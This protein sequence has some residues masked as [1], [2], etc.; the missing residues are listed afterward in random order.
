[1][2]DRQHDDQRLTWSVATA[3][4]IDHFY[5]ERPGPTMNA[6]AIKRGERPVAIIGMFRDGQRMRAFSEYV[7]EFEPH[8][9]SM[10]T[11][12]AIKAAQQM[13]REC[14]RPVIA[15]KGSDTGI[16]E[17]IGFVPVTDEVYSWRG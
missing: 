11:L 7:P 1:M 4:D 12:R 9:R 5:G 14:R 8:L 6:I 15:V 2:H 17:R 3:V 10:V 13:F 16:L